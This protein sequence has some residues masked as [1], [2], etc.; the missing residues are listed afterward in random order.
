MRTV[1]VSTCARSAACWATSSAP[2]ASPSVARLATSSSRA[3]PRTSASAGQAIPPADVSDSSERDTGALEEPT[4]RRV[5]AQTDGT[6]ESP[7]LLEVLGGE[8]GV[9]ANLLGGL[10]RS[11]TDLHGDV[12][13]S[14]L[15]RDWIK[16]ARVHLDGAEGC[17]EAQRNVEGDGG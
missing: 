17:G 15:G 1:I 3:R 5:F 6:A 14:A 16:P 11:R 13:P 8:R 12:D 2:S 7:C 4:R 9:D 10:P